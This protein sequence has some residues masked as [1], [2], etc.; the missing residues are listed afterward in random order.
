MLTAAMQEEKFSFNF[1]AQAMCST[2]SS[3]AQLP[4]PAPHEISVAS[5]MGEPNQDPWNN[6]PVTVKD[7][8]ATHSDS[9]WQVAGSRE[10][11]AI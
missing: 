5:V 3:L 10:V 6:L 9:L 4:V 1:T 2:A 8:T 11:K 7:V